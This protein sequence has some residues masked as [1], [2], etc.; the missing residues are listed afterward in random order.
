MNI[1]RALDKQALVDA[2]NKVR[3]TEDPPSHAVMLKYSR[4]WSGG[5]ISSDGI[6]AVRIS[7]VMATDP[8]IVELVDGFL[9][10]GGFRQLIK[11]EDYALWLL[12]LFK[13]LKN[14][15]AAVDKFEAVIMS[16]V[17]RVQTC[18]LLINVPVKTA[19]SLRG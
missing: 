6:A 3:P 1:T 16:N 14:A 18:H 12:T 10:S 7:E 5:R 4:L 11:L 2:L 8:V 15:R 19:I 17:A 9:V 13:S